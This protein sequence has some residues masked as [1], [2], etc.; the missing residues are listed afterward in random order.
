M[1]LGAT[2]NVTYPTSQFV[3]GSAEC[4]EV[5]PGGWDRGVMIF[6]GKNH[7][8]RRV[9]IE[10]CIEGVCGG[11]VNRRGSEKRM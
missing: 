11:N 1:Q 7:R 10:V 6:E 8:L 9:E 3:G 2:A 4:I 5:G